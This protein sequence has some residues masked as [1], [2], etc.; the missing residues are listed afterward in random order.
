MVKLFG[1]IALFLSVVLSASCEKRVLFW[2]KFKWVDRGWLFY[3]D[4]YTPT[5]T[6]RDARTLIV[7][8]RFFEKAPGSPTAYQNY[9]RL[10]SG[11][12]EVKKDGLHALALEHCNGMGIVTSTKKFSYL[13]A[14]DKAH[15]NQ[16]LQEYGC[17]RRPY[18]HTN[19]VV[20]VNKII[21]VPDGTFKTYVIRHFNGDLSYWDPDYG[22]I[23]YDRYDQNGDLIGSLKLTRVDR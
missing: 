23:M 2:K 6:V 14:P 19:M 13:Y 5:D 4:Y 15:L 18:S 8:D 22:I 7:H 21:T 20:E 17:E 3:Y 10:A 11:D 16:P 9:F 12:V 1:I